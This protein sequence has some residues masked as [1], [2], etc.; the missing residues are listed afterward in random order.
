MVVAENQ[1]NLI[2]RSRRTRIAVIQSLFLKAFYKDENLSNEETLKQIKAYYQD[3]FK[4]AFESYLDHSLIDNIL[5]Y[6]QQNEARLEQEITDLMQG[7]PSFNRL[8]MILQKILLSGASEIALRTDLDLAIILNEYVE[9]TK[10]FEDVKS[11]RFV[12]G[13]LQSFANLKRN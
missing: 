10:A 12:N 4:M 6:C 2:S 9:I 5:L 13:L 3:H 7:K 11:A 1:E 8:S